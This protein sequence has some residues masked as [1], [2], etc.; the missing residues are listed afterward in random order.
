MSGPRRDPGELDRIV[1]MLRARIVELVRGIWDLRDGHQE[2]NDWVCRNPLRADHSARSFRIALRGPLQ[3]LVKDFAGGFGRSGKETMSPLTFHAEL[4]HGGDIGPAIK[5]A[6]A[7]LGLDGT[8]VA[9]L[10]ITR[11][12]VEAYQ[13][14]PIQNEEQVAA[15]RRLAQAVYLEGQPILGTPGWHYFK[16]RGLDLSRLGGPWGALRFNPG[17][18]CGEL[19][20]KLPAVVMPINAMDGGFLG[21]HRIWIDQTR[22]GRWVKYPA[23]GKNAKKAFGA[24]AGGVIRLWNGQRVLAR[25]GEVVYGRDFASEKG[26]LRIHM[27]EGP[28]DAVAVALACPDERVHCAVSVSNWQGIAYPDKV[29]E[30]VLWRQADPPS[31]PAA[32]SFFKV[33]QN[34]YAQGKTVKI[35]DIASVM[36]GVKDPAEAA[37]WRPEQ[38]GGDHA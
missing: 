8:D 6:K 29:T 35:A 1:D 18:Y 38:A 33:L 34:Q 21:V 28:E 22:D 15:R 7:W 9:S 19:K 24:Y 27:T 16:D 36:P 13:A 37:A 26:P 14:R 10:R 23:L 2:G 30:V 12:A 32:K 31:S 20:R 5:W 4:C 3:G 11:Q 25:T 17:C